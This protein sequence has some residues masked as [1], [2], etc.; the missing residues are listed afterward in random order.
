MGQAGVEGALYPE[1]IAEI[2]VR[3]V[4]RYRYLPSAIAVGF[5]PLPTLILLARRTC[6]FDVVPGSARLLWK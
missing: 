4:Y 5:G 6:F 2:Q 1:R 3:L